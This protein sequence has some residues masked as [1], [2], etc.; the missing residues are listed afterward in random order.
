MEYGVELRFLREVTIGI[1]P[2][3]VVRLTTGH[4]HAKALRHI[5][6]RRRGTHSAHWT[7][8]CSLH[9]E[10]VPVRAR[11]RE[12]GHI[13]VHTVPQFR[14]RDF[15]ATAHDAAEPLV[16][17]HFP[18]HLHG[19]HRH[20][21][22]FLEWR[23]GQARPDHEAI[24]QRISGSD[25]QCERIGA[26]SRRSPCPDCGIQAGKQRKTA[27]AEQEPAAI[28]EVEFRHASTC[29]KDESPGT[30]MAYPA[31]QQDQKR[32]RKPSVAF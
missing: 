27:S 30:P 18:T 20:A 21:A 28:Y 19:Q 10:A 12:P 2:A 29:A 23:R 6:R 3:L 9:K 14:P 17:G 15:L 24:R 13:H 4:C 7:A 32:A 11:R 1:E 5:S 8:V 26:E 25:T 22:M 31:H 16:L